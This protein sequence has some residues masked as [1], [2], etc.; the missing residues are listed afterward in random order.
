MAKQE[1]EFTIGH[2]KMLDFLAAVVR[3]IRNLH[4]A[5]QMTGA[6]GFGGWRQE[7]AVVYSASNAASKWG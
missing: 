6:S 1:E 5:G 2:A 4:I 3:K 7:E